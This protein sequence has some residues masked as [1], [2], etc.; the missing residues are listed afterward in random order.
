VGIQSQPSAIHSEVSSGG[1]S[2]FH[3]V[4]NFLGQV[5]GGSFGESR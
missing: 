3:D 1:I 4:F 2:V 5:I